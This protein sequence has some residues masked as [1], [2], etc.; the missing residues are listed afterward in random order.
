MKEP[1]MSLTREEVDHIAQLARLGLTEAETDLFAGQLSAILDYVQRLQ[2]LDTELV[3]PTT[4]A[5]PQ[6]NVTFEDVVEPSSVREAI[7]N[8]APDAA[9]GFFRVRAVLDF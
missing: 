5:I 8:G 3:P 9:D 7:L 6:Q 4:T 1:R 2:G